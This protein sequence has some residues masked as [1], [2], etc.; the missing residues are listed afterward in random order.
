MVPL[1]EP[2]REVLG[3][4]L[5]HLVV[6]RIHPRLAG[7]CRP[8]W[9]PLQGRDWAVRDTAPTCR[10]C[11]SA[12]PRRSTA[13]WPRST[14]STCAE[15]S[16]PRK[17]PASSCPRSR[18]GAREARRDPVPTRVERSRLPRDR[19]LALTPF[20]A[21]TRLAET[22]ALDL[23]DARL[24]APKGILRVVGKGEKIREIPI[25]AKLRD[26]LGAWLLDS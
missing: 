24:P 18:P 25:H 10:P 21:G 26:A 13:R 17:P 11:L 15:A 23:D 22:V 14:T 6:G 19:A 9:R 20:Y 16:A 7:R 5:E 4:V 3:E 2:T 1:L 12:N 8:R